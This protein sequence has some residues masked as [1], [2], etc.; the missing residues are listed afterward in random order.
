VFNAVTE[1]VT[2]AGVRTLLRLAPVVGLRVL[3]PGVSTA[4]ARE[5]LA[6]LSDPDRAALVRLFAGMR[7]G[8]GFLN[9]LRGVA[10][11]T[12]QVTQPVLIVASRQDGGVPFG[13][14]EALAASLPQAELVESGA[15]SHFIWFGDDYPAIAE[16]IRQFLTRDPTHPAG[17]GSR[18]EQH[19]GAVRPHRHCSADRPPSAAQLPDSRCPPFFIDEARAADHD[20]WASP[21][22]ARL[23]C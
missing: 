5:L 2:W 10:D 8:R 16:T 17:S 21:R 13:H 3:L 22:A 9:D 14:A 11:V 6:G 23:S 20:G 7:S 19:C 12:A 1:P 15:S 18:A 4:P